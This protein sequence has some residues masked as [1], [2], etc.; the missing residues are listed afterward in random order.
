MIARDNATRWLLNER[1]RALLA[2]EGSLPADGVRLADQEFRLGDR[3]IARR[4]D[5]HRDV[6]NGTLGRVAAIDAATGE[7]T[8]ITDSGRRC[9]LDAGY[10]AA[11]V[12][13]AYALT[14]HGAQGATLRWA[15]VIGRPEEFT[16]EWAYT[17]LSRARDTT[18]LHLIAEPPGDCRERA[19]YAP[20][21][22]TVGTTDALHRLQQAMTRTETE[23]LA[24][25]HE[26]LHAALTS[27][28][29]PT[30]TPRIR[31]SPRR[32]SRLAPSTRG[33]TLRQ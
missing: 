13:P 10:A 27:P 25:D 26:Q 24:L 11:H 18:T 22:P 1:A 15:G 12:E 9:V 33:P 5:R 20:I 7:L 23:A 30:P 21:T 14:G 3:V 8:L 31:R 32:T 17:A 16:R 4:N 2:A 28:V 19:A 6:D 29:I